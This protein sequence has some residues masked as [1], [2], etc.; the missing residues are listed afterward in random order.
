MFVP[1]QLRPIIGANTYNQVQQKLQQQPAA[2]TTVPQISVPPPPMP[3]AFISTFMPPQAVP[4]EKSYSSE[5]TPVVLSSAPKLYNN[6]P[7][8]IQPSEIPVVHQAPT[9]VRPVSAFFYL[10]YKFK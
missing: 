8:S 4:P 9:A 7:M 2:T 3:P 10:F 1:H 5:P 6:R